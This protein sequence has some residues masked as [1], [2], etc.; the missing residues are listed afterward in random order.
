MESK[1]TVDFIRM[2]PRKMR[3]V[4]DEVRGY[5]YPEAADILRAIPR[6]SARIILKALNSAVANAR[7]LNPEVDVNTLYIRK[8][9]IDAGPMLKRIMPRARGRGDRILKRTSRLTIVLSDEN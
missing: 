1:A 5:E 6:K 3:L 8:I 9:F 2:S 4:A 7:V